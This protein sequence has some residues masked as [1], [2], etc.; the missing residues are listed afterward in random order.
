MTDLSY[1]KTIDANYGNQLDNTI[2]NIWGDIKNDWILQPRESTITDLKLHI[3]GAESIQLNADI[4]DNYVESN[5]AFQEHI[6]LKPKIFTVSGEVGELTW[7][8]NDRV[9]SETLA[10]AQKLV[11]VVSFMPPISKKATA[12]QDKAMKIIGV[13]DSLDNF[14]NRVWQLLSNEDVDTEQKKSCKYLMVLWEAR[15]PINIKTPFGTLRNYVI[16]NIEFTQPERTK[17]KSKVKISFKEF[18]VVKE[19]INEFNEKEY[20]GSQKKYMK[21]KAP[22]MAKKEN[23]GK[24]TGVKLTYTTC[25]PGSIFVDEQTKM[26]RIVGGF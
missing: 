16:Q 8:K 19:K 5:V 25:Q 21:R 17:D 1:L 15:T 9:E 22:Q 23:K 4:T 7:Y 6:A 26:C 10:V 18:R 24:T 11:P 2:G 3:Y 20:K 12:I 13:V 14:A